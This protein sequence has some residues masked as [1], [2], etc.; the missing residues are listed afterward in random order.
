MV[1]RPTGEADSEPQQLI[2]LF[3]PA[4]IMILVFSLLIG[5]GCSGQATAADSPQ[6]ASGRDGDASVGAA[7]V[8][9]LLSIDD[10]WFHRLRLNRFT[11]A[12]AVRRA[13]L[14]PVFVNYRLLKPGVVDQILASELLDNVHGLVLAGGGDVDPESFG[15]L[16]E[17][18]LGVI[19]ERDRFEI[20][21]LREARRRGLPVLGICR[22]AQLINVEAGGTL[23]NLRGQPELAKRHRSWFQG[24]PVSLHAGTRLRAIYDQAAIPNVVTFHGQAVGAIGAGLRVA[25]QSPD[26]VV[27]AIESTDADGFGRI[28]VQWHAEYWNDGL[29]QPLFRHFAAAARQHAGLRAEADPH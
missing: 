12:R 23:I 10:T 9:V 11:Y 18:S 14:N 29:E 15:E 20:A 21:L 13:G 1:P 3:Q 22:G 2:V 16:P 19:H 7:G 24:H 27:E 5:T 4:A 26:G 25:A 28:G 8:G 6:N 17:F